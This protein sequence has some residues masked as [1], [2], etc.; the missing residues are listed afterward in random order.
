MRYITTYLT[1]K[2]NSQRDHFR[3]GAYT[4]GIDQLSNSDLANAEIYYLEN[5]EI[6][7]LE[8]VAYA[9]NGDFNRRAGV[10][11]GANI[12]NTTQRLLNFRGDFEQLKYQDSSQ[13]GLSVLEHKLN[14]LA[15]SFDDL[16]KV[17]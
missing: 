13:N 1:A 8:N 16:F 10:R 15:S 9:K 7:Y 14:A 3:T 6:Y 11:I 12:T 17:L 2:K 4:E 5:V